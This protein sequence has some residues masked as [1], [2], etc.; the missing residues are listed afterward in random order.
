MPSIKDMI[1]E[2]VEKQEHK[3]ESSLGTLNT[4]MDAFKDTLS[5]FQ[6]DTIEALVETMDKKTQFNKKF[7]TIEKSIHSN[8]QLMEIM[9]N[10][11]AKMAASIQQ[12][13]Q[14]LEAMNGKKSEPIEEEQQP[15]KKQR[16]SAAIPMNLSPSIS[17][18]P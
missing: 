9:Q 13:N 15:N 3:Y 16:E 5:T 7:E 4:R 6:E 17:Q 1:M 14:T 11:M 2:A 18:N 8:L 12:L 10:N